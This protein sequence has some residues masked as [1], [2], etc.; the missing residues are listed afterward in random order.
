[1]S[2]TPHQAAIRGRFTAITVSLHDAGRSSKPAVLAGYDACTMAEDIHQ[3][4]QQLG[5]DSISVLVTTAG[6]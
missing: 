5:L 3:L 2:L 1:V 6:W 4:M